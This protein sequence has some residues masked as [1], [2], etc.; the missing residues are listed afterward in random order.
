MA[1]LTNIPSIGAR[2]RAAR[3]QAGLTQVQLARRAGV[4]RYTLVKLETGKLPDVTVKTLAS[5]L[6]VVGLELHVDER[7]VS[8][9]PILGEVNRSDD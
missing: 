9:L 5:I 8:G 6:N 1:F 2:V 4:S 3:K 7:R